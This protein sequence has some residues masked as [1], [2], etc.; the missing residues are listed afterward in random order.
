MAKIIAISWSI[1]SSKSVTHSEIVFR[2]LIYYFETY[3]TIE[4]YLFREEV[5]KKGRKNSPPA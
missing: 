5:G 1:F 3:F 2:E 4:L